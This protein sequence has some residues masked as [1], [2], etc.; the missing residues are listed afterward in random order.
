MKK[1]NQK[2]FGAVEAIIVLVVV[3]LLGA[4]GWF[5]YDKNHNSKVST[6]PTPNTTPSARPTDDAS[7][8]YLYTSY[9]GT[10]KIRLADGLTFSRNS[11]SSAICTRGSVVEL[12]STTAK[13]E[14][15][16]NGH[17][18]GGGLCINYFAKSSDASW[19]FGEKRQGFKTNAGLEVEKYYYYQ[20]TEPEAAGLRKGDEEYTYRIIKDGKAVVIAYS[21]MAG[22]KANTD[23]VEKMVKTVELP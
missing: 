3:V 14:I 9:D 21:V 5:V 2:G 12:G 19:D 6:T 20:A 13:V 16:N 18:G 10:Y 8:W 1:L 23:L 22:E 7:K 4:A 15:E 17:E 11:D